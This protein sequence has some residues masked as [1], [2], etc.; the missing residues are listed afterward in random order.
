MATKKK[1]KKRTKAQIRKSDRDIAKRTRA[2]IEKAFGGPS[3][4]ERIKAFFGGG[5]KKKKR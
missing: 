3:D 1:K 4:L 5:K 2:G